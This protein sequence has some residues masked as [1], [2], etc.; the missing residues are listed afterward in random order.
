MAEPALRTGDALPHYSAHQWVGSSMAAVGRYPD[1]FAHLE[2]ALELSPKSSE[3]QASLAHAYA[4]GGRSAEA[5]RLL[6]VLVTS[7]AVDHYAVATAHAAC[8]FHGC[9][10]NWD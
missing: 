2:R 8:A 10:A 6:Q 3:R 7:G 5:A 4:I 9:C 1:A